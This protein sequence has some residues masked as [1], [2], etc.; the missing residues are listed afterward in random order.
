MGRPDSSQLIMACISA[1]ANDPNEPC[2]ADP[3]HQDSRRTR[4]TSGQLSPFPVSQANC[5][6][7]ALRIAEDLRYTAV[8]EHGDVEDVFH[9]TPVD[10]VIIDDITMQS[11]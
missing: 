2:A 6:G 4:F 7:L 1:I 9:A 8:L 10:E 3:R 5:I 11:G